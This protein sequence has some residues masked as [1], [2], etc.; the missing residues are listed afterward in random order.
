MNRSV[1]TGAI[2]TLL[3]ISAALPVRAAGVELRF[4]PDTQLWSHPLESQRQMHS[5]VVQNTAIVNRSARP[6]TVERLHFEL[7]SDETVI[8]SR[9]LPTATLDRVA[10]GSAALGQ[11]GMMEA[12]DFQFAPQILFG[13]AP[14]TLGDSR[15]LPPGGALF[16]PAQLLAW[17][18]SAGTLRVRAELRDAETVSGSLPI[19]GDAAP[20]SWRFPL[21]GH[22]LVGAGATPHSH[23]RWGVP[24]EFAL[25]LL[26]MGADGKSFRGKGRRMRDYHAYGAPVLASA[27]GE[28]VKVH[29]GEPDN[30]AMLRG[31]DESLADYNTRLRAGQDALLAAGHDRIAGNHVVIRHRVE[32]TVLFSVY[33][34]LKPGSVKVAVGAQVQAGQPLAALGGSGNSTEPHLHFHVC[35]APQPLRCAG[36]PVQF[37]NVELP[38]SDVPRLLQSGDLVTVVE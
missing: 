23:H 10:R 37:S 3:S 6:V 31:P 36:V 32:G 34:H 19:R 14:Y 11:S 5:V 35:D 7:L 9:T 30:V 27:E 1:I 24:E 29:D 25:D 4:Y 20:G 22:W 15:T 26:R 38:W 16:V 28:V 12:V 33:A 2:A 8:E 17:Q 13:A 21:A 18:G